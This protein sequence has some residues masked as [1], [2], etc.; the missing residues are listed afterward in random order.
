[1]NNLIIK[2]PKIYKNKVNNNNCIYQRGNYR[3]NNFQMN[4]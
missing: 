1:M 4:I 2:I 3:K